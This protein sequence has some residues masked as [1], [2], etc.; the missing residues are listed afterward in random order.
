MEML[1]INDLSI[2]QSNK[3][4][5]ENLSLTF[6]PGE[7]W[8]I[9]GPNGSGKST[10]LHTLAGLHPPTAGEIVLG[11]DPLQRLSRKAIAQ[12][13]GIL[14]QQS[15]MIFTQRVVDYCHA[16]RFP[17]RHS[18]NDPQIT[19][20]ALADVELT[21]RTQDCITT[22][23]GGEKKR[24]AIAKLLTQTPSIYL[25]D[26]PTN[27]LDIRYQVKLLKRFR[28]LAHQSKTILMALHDINQAQQYCDHVLLLLP[29]GKV[30]SGLTRTLLTAENLS[31]LY[32]HPIRAIT[33]NNVIYWVADNTD[34]T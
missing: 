24:L 14:F 19:L 33:Q 5:I 32:H 1:R 2:D 22:L 11:S 28:E 16:G 21:D 12:R 30:K 13:L 15:N 10:L 8:G 4:L 17:H 7:V 6:H 25:L 9:L 20:T 27:H 34:H 26:E 18:P 29:N 31:A 3:R 23:S